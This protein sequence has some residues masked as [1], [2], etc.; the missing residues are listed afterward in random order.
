MS[1]E[2]F[3]LFKSCIVS[4][5]TTSDQGTGFFV[6]SGKILTCKHVIES[7]RDNEIEVLWNKK[8]YQVIKFSSS[9]NYDLA[10]LNIPLTIHPCVYLD[11]KEAL[12]TQKLYSYGYPDPNRDGN[13]ITL[14]CEG[15]SDNG[16]LLTVKGGNVISGFSGAPLLNLHTRKVCGVIAKK[17]KK[18]IT[19]NL[20]MNLGGQS[21]TLKVIFTNYPELKS[22]N[23]E[24]LTKNPD[25]VNIITSSKVSDLDW[26]S[27]NFTRDRIFNYIKV[28]IFLIGVLASWTFLGFFAENAFPI[29]SAFDL[30]LSCFGNFGNKLQKQYQNL[31][32]SEISPFSSEL[33]RRKLNQ[34]DSQNWL[35][36]ELL[37]Q[38]CQ[39]KYDSHQISRFFWKIENL[40]EQRFTILEL[41]KVEG[42][43][44]HFMEQIKQ[45][46]QKI[47]FLLSN[48]STKDY[49][50]L[51]EILDHIIYL[52]INILKFVVSESNFIID[53][54]CKKAIDSKLYNNT[55]NI[56]I[57]KLLD[58]I[59]D[60]SQ[61]ILHLAK[62]Q[63]LENL[64]EQ[65]IL[66]PR[67]KALYK[68]SLIVEL[69]SYGENISIADGEKVSI[70]GGF[71]RVWDTSPNRRNKYHFHRK[72]TQY[73]ERVKPEEQKNIK[74]FDTREQA[75]KSGY[76]ACQT[77]ISYDTK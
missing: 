45:G 22:K 54:F 18:S 43:S 11:D 24:F 75:E 33:G 2:L 9:D 65:L 16:Q 70:K 58:H 41:K 71:V 72:C 39:N 26:K 47:P 44:F 31:S 19:K 56:K 74:C 66:N 25:W 32:Q 1:D 63:T 51:E 73:P 76:E 52:N 30:F 6:A 15:L 59:L 3:E 13:S 37:V 17:R 7:A 46:L 34:L 14:D 21:I 29:K 20:D 23:R 38:T 27:L 40:E 69:L 62:R 49:I 61:N 55:L 36:K 42:K 48:R 10:I 50:K 77:C 5:K 4:I 35:L 60:E 64:E 68:I 67:L 12:P 53:D 8:T 28:F 57:I